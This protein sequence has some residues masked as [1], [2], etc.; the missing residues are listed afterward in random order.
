MENKEQIFLGENTILHVK[1]YDYFL[2]SKNLLCN[3]YNFNSM[4]DSGCS[5][6][7]K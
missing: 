4:D 1:F 2:Y 7:F 6:W 5:S 3:F